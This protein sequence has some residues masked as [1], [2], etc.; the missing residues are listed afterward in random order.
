MGQFNEY[1]IFTSGN[2][3]TTWNSLLYVNSIDEGLGH[4]EFIAADTGCFVPG[5]FD[6]QQVNRS[7]NALQNYEVCPA[8]GTFVVADLEMLHYNEIFV[9]DY[10]ARFWRLEEDTL[11]VTAELGLEFYPFNKP[12][13]SAATDE[14]LFIACKA[15]ENGIY[16]NDLILRSLD[17]GNSWDT[18]YLSET[19]FLNDV[20]FASGSLGF[21]VGDNGIILKTENAGESWEIKNS[22]VQAN[23]ISIDFRDPLT[24][25]IGAEGTM[26]ITWDGGD[27]WVPK[28][29]PNGG[30]T[31]NVHFPEKDNIVYVGSTGL[32]KTD[33]DFLTGINS[34]QSLNNSIKLFPNPA[35]SKVCIE[36]QPNVITLF[37][38]ELL[39]SLGTVLHYR[40]NLSLSYT[41]S[42]NGLPDGLYFIRILGNDA[43][44]KEGLLIQK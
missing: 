34:S 29:G 30:G 13:L 36:V 32:W 9:L 24:W 8:E 6:A 25:L 22:G 40:E 35:D 33:I 19:V 2:S 3:G 1:E 43:C 10:D 14:H 15:K 5:L 42:L 17:G 31:G 11:S 39:N 41:I 44:F 18:S 27:T 12:I 20:Q 16:K 4:I 38:I 26:L 23:L 7:A 37:N 28:Y 21:A